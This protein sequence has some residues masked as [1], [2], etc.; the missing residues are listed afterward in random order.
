MINDIAPRGR[1]TLPEKLKVEVFNRLRTWT[2]CF[3]KLCVFQTAKDS[4]FLS[5]FSPLIRPGLGEGF[6]IGE[7]LGLSSSSGIE[8]DSG[9]VFHK[10][11][12]RETRLWALM[13]RLEAVMSFFRTVFISS[14]YKT[15]RTFKNYL[16]VSVLVCSTSILVLQDASWNL[17][18]GTCLPEIG[19]VSPRLQCLVL[20]C[21]FNHVSP[22]QATIAWGMEKVMKSLIK[23]S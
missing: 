10:E 11:L 20:K 2:Q 6:V 14:E 18:I 1:A 3:L 9:N 17:W 4:E 13:P 21:S 16:S 23:I 5:S 19:Q 15:L 8:T 7:I 12:R 22:A